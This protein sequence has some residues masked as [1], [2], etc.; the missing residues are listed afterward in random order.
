MS[1]LSLKG[2][3]YLT[4]SH[5]KGHYKL[6]ELLLPWQLYHSSQMKLVVFILYYDE[7]VAYSGQK[8][9]NIETRKRKRE[10]K[11]QKQP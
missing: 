7:N 9:L 10:K 2:E 6:L 8:Y 1:K 3:M 4:P 5:T 11:N